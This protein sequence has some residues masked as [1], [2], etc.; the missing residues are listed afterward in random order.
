M[1]TYT[2]MIKTQFF[3]FIEFLLF[4]VQQWK[5]DW[6]KS[7]ATGRDASKKWLTLPLSFITP[8][9]M[10]MNVNVHRVMLEFFSYIHQLSFATLIS[11]KRKRRKQMNMVCWS[12]GWIFFGLK[13]Y[14]TLYKKVSKINYFKFAS[15]LHSMK[16]E[17]PEITKRAVWNHWIA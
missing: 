14:V 5:W 7:A 10:I 16:F 1:F 15:I 12:K 11:G 4:F 3:T 17:F 8:M 2:H 6:T 13:T 9:M